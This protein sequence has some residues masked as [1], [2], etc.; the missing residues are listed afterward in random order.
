M[1][2]RVVKKCCHCF[3]TVIISYNGAKGGKAK[4][5][6]PNFIFENVFVKC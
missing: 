6:K 5:I 1:T 2:I 4:I 3:K